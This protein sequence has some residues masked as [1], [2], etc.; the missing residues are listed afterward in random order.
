MECSLWQFMLRDLLRRT[1]ADFSEEIP[2][3]GSN[4]CFRLGHE[5]VHGC[6]VGER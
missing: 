2:A 6:A 1:T 4:Q 3:K 5:L